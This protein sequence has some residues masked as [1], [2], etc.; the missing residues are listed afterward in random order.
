MNEVKID[1]NCAT[2]LDILMAL[3][4]MRAAV[5]VRAKHGFLINKALAIISSNPDVVAMQAAKTA[6]FQKYGKDWGNGLVQIPA[7]KVALF[8]GEVG[9]VGLLPVSLVLPAIPHAVKAKLGESELDVEPA[10]LDALDVLWG[11]E[12]A[13]PAA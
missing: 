13:E 7:H 3:Q 2:A 11:P 1:T 4:W 10:L 12:D 5:R 6:A 9:E 8:N